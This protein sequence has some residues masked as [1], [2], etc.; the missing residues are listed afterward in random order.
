MN[1]PI[2][3]ISLGNNQANWVANLYQ[4]IIKKD[5]SFAFEAD[6]YYAIN[7]ENNAITPFKKTYQ[8]KNEYTFAKYGIRYFS[9]FLSKSF[10]KEYRFVKAVG[11]KK[12]KKD[13]ISLFFKGFLTQKIFFKNNNYDVYHFHFLKFEYLFQLF[14]LPQNKKI[15]CSFWG[16][17]L[18]R[19]NG[20]IQY[21]FQQK[22]LK[23]ANVITVQNEEMVEVVLAKFGRELKPKIKKLLFP[24]DATL[25]DALD[26]Y[27]NNSNEINQFKKEVLNLSPTQKVVAIGHNANKFNNHLAILQY[28]NNLDNQLKEETHFVFLMTYGELNKGEYINELMNCCKTNN[29]QHHFFSE[30]L[31]TKDL[32]LL[33]LATDVFVHLPES[34]AMSGSLIEAA[35]AGNNIITG[36]WLPYSRFTKAGIQYSTIS[37]YYELIPQ[38]KNQLN[39]PISTTNVY[40]NITGIK[41]NFFEDII[42]PEWITVYKEL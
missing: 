35:Y 24:L 38:L 21:H 14:F 12:Q 29:I 9:F 31:S 4:A 2:K 41:A 42:A 32:A 40:K 30:Y 25:F 5:N 37:N 18:F 26:L 1:K 8:F 7:N 28:L 39:T 20:I 19:S 36:S 34:D 11:N 23:R 17:D 15:I 10:W 33:K 16:S 13:F 27:R 6:S 22:A 3:I